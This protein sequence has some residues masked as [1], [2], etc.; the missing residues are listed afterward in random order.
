MQSFVNLRIK[1]KIKSRLYFFFFFMSQDSLQGWL[2]MCM[3]VCLFVRG[4][5]GKVGEPCHDLGEYR[6]IS[7]SF[8]ALVFIIHG[9]SSTL[10]RITWLPCKDSGLGTLVWETPWL[11]PRSLIYN[12][13]P[14]LP[15]AQ[16]VSEPRLWMSVT[17]EVDSSHK[18]WSGIFRSIFRTI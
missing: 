8:N 6:S 11:W 5:G 13:R 9:F 17:Y 14:T 3:F 7:C 16:G 4:D 12:A 1:K 15:W 18:L 10:N 2:W